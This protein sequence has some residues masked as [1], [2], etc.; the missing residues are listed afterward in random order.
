MVNFFSAALISMGFLT[1]TYADHSAQQITTNKNTEI[2]TAKALKKRMN[3]N[4]AIVAQGDEIS[5]EKKIAREKGSEKETGITTNANVNA[6]KKQQAVNALDFHPAQIHDVTQAQHKAQHTGITTNADNAPHH[7]AAIE[8]VKHRNIDPNI[9]WS[10]TAKG[11][12]DAQKSGVT[13]G[14]DNDILSAK[15][16]AKKQASAKLAEVE[17]NSDTTATNN[18]ADGLL[19]EY[20][21]TEE[22]IN[23]PIFSTEAEGINDF[24]NATGITEANQ[25]IENYAVQTGD[26][27]ANTATNDYNET[28]NTIDNMF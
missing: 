10:E 1:N 18:D 21:D 7:P 17:S 26:S 24:K 3:S 27:I 15:A 4:Y 8:T 12:H 13:T 14:A 5:E 9:A 25:A 16:A 11:K 20:V 23:N 2:N 22:E 28:V 19:N 6:L